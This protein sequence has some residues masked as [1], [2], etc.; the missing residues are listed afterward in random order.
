MFQEDYR[1]SY[2]GTLTGINLP[3]PFTSSSVDGCLTFRFR[4]DGSVNGAGWNA[5]VTCAPPPTCPKPTALVTSNITQNS[6][7]VTWTEVGSATSWEVIVQPASAPA[8]TVGSTGTI[9]STNSYTINTLSP[10]TQYVIYIRSLCSTSDIS[11]WSTPK[12]FTTLIANDECINATIAPVN[13]STTCTQTV[14]G[15]VIGATASTEPNAC[16][17]TSDDDVWFQ[18]TATSTTHTISLLNITGS[19]TDLFHVL[20]SG[21]CGAL[22]QL[23]CSDPN[24]STANNLVVGQ[25][26]FVRVLY[27]FF[28]RE[29]NICF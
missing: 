21:S 24:A 4:S 20:Y 16:F 11:L 3:G 5:N 9:V 22:T 2:W 19:T 28:D 25:T 10:G 26:Y 15:T 7:T 6:M 29:S 12:L 8:P 23:Y 1:V 17:G 27:L 14:S 13:I 18:F